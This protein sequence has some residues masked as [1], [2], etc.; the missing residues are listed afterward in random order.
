MAF[1]RF[2]RG[3][4]GRSALAAVIVVAL[5]LALGASAFLLLLQRELISTVQS[6]AKA[7]ATEVAT[8]V[9]R[10]GIAGLGGDLSGTGGAQVVQV[11]DDTG[12]VV[13][14]SSDRARVRPLAQ[15][16]PAAGEVREVR[17]S[18]LTLFDDDNPYL[19]AVAGVD[20]AGDYYRVIVAT[21]VGAQQES[22][23]TA[24]TLLLI[25]FPV[26]LILVGVATWLLVG[27]ALQPVERIRARV[28]EIRGS[29][30]KERIPVPSS[31]DEVERLA[32][33]MNDMLARLDRVLQ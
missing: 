3:V 24:L 14:A 18:R 2:L 19:V 10:E 15:I 13:S 16:R 7:R 22:V 12:R 1:P 30:V 11:V 23:R 4:R 27:R 6:A 20:S 17:S 29:A 31:G 5:G 25:G 21:P 26:L 32:A 8:Q 28:A 9:A 33:T